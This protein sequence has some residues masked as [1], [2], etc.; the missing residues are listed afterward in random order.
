MNT[1]NRSENAGVALL[2][3]GTVA[4]AFAAAVPD[5]RIAA[6]ADRSG[7]LLLDD[8]GELGKLLAHKAAGKSLRA[9]PAKTA[10]LTVPELLRSLPRLGV[11]VLVESLPSDLKNGQ[12]ALDWLCSSLASGISVVTVDKGPL[13]HGFDRLLAAAESGGARLAFQGTTG[14]WPTTDVRGQVV[15]EIEGILNG[16][17][18]Y[19]LSAM[20]ESG[21]GFEPALREAQRR[22]IAEPDPRQDLEGWDSAAKILILSQALMN[23]RV[24]LAAVA[25]TGIGPTTQTM[26]KKARS[27]GRAVRLIARARLLSGRVQLS[28]APEILSPDSP[29]YPISGTSKAAIFRTAENGQLFVSSTSGLDA[30]S[31]IIMDDIRSVGGSSTR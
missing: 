21:L 5:L 8:P 20:C 30:I 14:V 22:G 29:F 4:R 28:V 10:M 24:D 16:T 11:H 26:V 19:I 23:A 15:A 1:Q 7:A 3:F 6:V 2:G 13:V 17:T 12:P 25:R 9:W 27:T 18:N 31:E